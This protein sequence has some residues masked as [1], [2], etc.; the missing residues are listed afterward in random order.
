MVTQSALPRPRRSS[1]TL[2]EERENR[3]CCVGRQVGPRKVEKW[4]V[5]SR[6]IEEAKEAAE[7]SHEKR[8]FS[9]LAEERVRPVR[10]GL[11]R[12][13]LSKAWTGHPKM[14][15]DG[16]PEDRPSP[17]KIAAAPERTERSALSVFKKP[18]PPL[19]VDIAKFNR[20][21]ISEAITRDDAEI[22]KLVLLGLL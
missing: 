16:G 15:P 14:Y 6:E 4:S 17:E 22:E 11:C 18:R 2:R 1:E 9:V 3:L 7:L 21:R 10:A 19:F 20:K 8:G 12:A 5:L 13:G